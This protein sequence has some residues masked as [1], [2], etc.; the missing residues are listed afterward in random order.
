VETI[1]H[2]GNI[3]A[4]LL[5]A[6]DSYPGITFFTPTE[7]SQQ[8]GLL[9][10]KVGYNVKP[11]THNRMKRQVFNTQEVLIIRKGKVKIFL[12]T[13]AREFLRSLILE[14][15]DLILLASGG[16]G[17]EVLEDAEMIEVKQGPYFDSMV[18]KTKFEMP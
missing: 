9:N 1:K 3:I 2:A 14:S 16:H 6:G 10:H 8:L 7:F 17:L 15:G 18:D 12:Y 13:E 5:R 11:H 4:L